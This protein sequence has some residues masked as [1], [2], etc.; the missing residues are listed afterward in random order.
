MSDGVVSVLLWLVYVLGWWQLRHVAERLGR[1]ALR[2][3]WW[4][5]ALWCAVGIPSALQFVR[6][7]LLDVGARDPEAIRDGQW[8]RL[9]TSMF[10][11]DGGVAGTV[12]NLVT[13]GLT[14]VLVAAV[15]RPW[16][17]PVVFVAGGVAC[18]IVTVLTFG[19]S[20]AGNS[21]AT[22]VLLVS[23]AVWSGSRR[24][25]ADV[26]RLLLIAAAAVALL[27]LRN[28]HGIAVGLGLAAGLLG[29]RVVEPMRSRRRAGR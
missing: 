29:T 6:P 21:M 17:L 10:L 27:G 2:I 1:P 16:L 9:V 24:A 23:T 25:G 8:W 26:V 12:F 19:Q 28:Q 7:V 3:G 20:G 14:V 13:L 5:A 22:L 15:V 11:Q 4:G 18:N